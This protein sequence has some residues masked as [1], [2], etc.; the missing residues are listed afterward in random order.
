MAML[1]AMLCML[2]GACLYA[3]QLPWVAWWQAISRANHGGES[4]D[5]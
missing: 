5:H 2:L 1:G 4:D 3:S